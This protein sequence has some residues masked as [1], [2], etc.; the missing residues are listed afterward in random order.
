MAIA[1]GEFDAALL[2]DGFMKMAKGEN[3]KHERNRNGV[4]N[5]PDGWGIAYLDGGRFSKYKKEVPVWEDKE[6]EKFRTIKTSVTILHAR[7]S[8]AAKRAYEN[9]QPFYRK[10]PGNE[11][12]FCHNG[13]IR[14]QLTFGT[15]FYPLGETDSER[16]FYY[17]LSSARENN[18]G[19]LHERLLALK[20]YTAAN[21]ILSNTSTAYAA[22]QYSEKPA[23]YS[24]KLYFADNYL[25]VSSEVLPG[26]SD[27]KWRPLKNGSL[28]EIKLDALEYRIKEYLVKR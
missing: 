10:F 12:I 14:E 21:M 9:T 5:H 13:T 2:L 1:V 16:L 27:A 11:Y 19:S 7:R 15:E 3:E 4:Y 24:M 26:F 25:I 6:F 20:D 23:Y 18:E 8:S 17:L 22:V 28:I